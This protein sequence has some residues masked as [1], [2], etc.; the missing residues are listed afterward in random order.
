M[1]PISVRR[2]MDPKCTL[3][4]TQCQSQAVYAENP[5]VQRQ[6]SWAGLWLL[7]KEVDELSPKL[8]SSRYYEQGGGVLKARAGL[9][10]NLVGKVDRARARSLVNPRQ[11]A[12]NG[13]FFLNGSEG[14]VGLRREIRDI[15]GGRGQ[16][17]F[18][19]VQARRRNAEHVHQVVN[20][21]PRL[22]LESRSLVERNAGD[23]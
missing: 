15:V 10:D 17:H 9:L 11:R 14:A 2:L 3:V 12:T 22:A 4:I 20:R 5:C 6:V 16:A 18:G 1:Y 19:A 8:E 23:P 13:D 21:Q 7:P